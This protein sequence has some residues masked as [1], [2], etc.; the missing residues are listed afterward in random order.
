MK[1][2]DQLHDQDRM[3]DRDRIH[4]QDGRAIY[5]YQLM[6]PAER[7]TY[8]NHMRS[9]KTVQERNAYRMEHR[10]E[11]QQRAR[12]R[13]VAMPPDSGQGTQRQGGDGGN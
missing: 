12:E 1:D 6:T 7:R 11:M 5:G 13:G 8:M 10:N 2:R 4:D 3:R 9:L